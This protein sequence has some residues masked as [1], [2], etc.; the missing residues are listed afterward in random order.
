MKAGMG[1]GLSGH[2]F[3]IPFMLRAI[4]LDEWCDVGN[5]IIRL[6]RDQLFASDL[7]TG[8]AAMILT[9]DPLV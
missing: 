2:A 5:I 3:L 4:Q 7:S 9:P 8:R 6:S 1:F